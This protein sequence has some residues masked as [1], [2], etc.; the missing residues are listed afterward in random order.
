MELR[1]KRFA[2]RNLDQISESQRFISERDS[3][4]R[5]D[6]VGAVVGAGAGLAGMLAG[7][8]LGTDARIG[9]EQ[10]GRRPEK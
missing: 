5:R 7:G 9:S 1:L 3:G 4:S 8:L 10:P 6:T 2:G